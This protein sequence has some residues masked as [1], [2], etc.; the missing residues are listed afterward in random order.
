MSGLYYGAYGTTTALVIVGL[1]KI[2]TCDEVPREGTDQC[3]RYALQWRRRSIQCTASPATLDLDVYSLLTKRST[4]RP[5]PRINLTIRM[6]RHGHRPLHRPISS[7]SS[8][9][10]LYEIGGNMQ[11]QALRDFKGN[12]YHRHLHPRRRCKGTPNP[13]QEPHLNHFL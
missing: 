2:W 3:S 1:C 10:S 8:V 12:L 13:N 4:G 5:I 6:G 7:R 11:E 9:V